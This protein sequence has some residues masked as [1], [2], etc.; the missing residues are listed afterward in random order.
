MPPVADHPI[1]ISALTAEPALLVSHYDVVPAA[2]SDGWSHDPFDADVVDGAGADVDI[3]QGFGEARAR[4]ARIIARGTLDIKTG[5]T[6]PLEGVSLLLSQGFQPKRTVILAF[7]HEEEVGGEYGAKAV[8]SLLRSRGTRLALVV[9]EG[10]TILVDG[11]GGGRLASGPV[12]I[13]GTAE[14]GYLSLRA[15]ILVPEPGHR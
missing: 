7:G 6:G 15:D 2:A 1:L 4:G 9:D 14:K 5:V 12:A 3:R 10:G 11:I 8:A 13:V